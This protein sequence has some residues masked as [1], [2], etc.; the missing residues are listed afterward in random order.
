MV[1]NMSDTH[2]NGE[3]NQ[4][5]TPA[6]TANPLFEKSL[7]F[8]HFVKLMK[9]AGYLPF[10]LNSLFS[11]YVTILDMLEK[12]KGDP[13]ATLI[14]DGPPGVGK[15]FMAKAFAEVMKASY[16][17]YNC[18]PE[19]SAEELA[20]DINIIIP[21]LANSGMLT[22]EPT[23]EELILVG[24]LL[25]AI[26][27]S[28]TQRVVFL[29]DEQDKARSVVDALLLGVLQ[30]GYMFVNGIGENYRAKQVFSDPGNLIV[31]ITKNDERDLHPALLRRGRVIYMDYPPRSVE[32][33]LLDKRITQSAGKTVIPVYDN[34]E[35]ILAALTGI[36]EG[37][38]NGLITKARALRSASSITKPPSSPELERLANDFVRFIRANIRRVTRDQQ[39]WLVCDVPKPVLDKFM[40]DS[41]LAIKDEQS[42]GSK[43]MR[44]KSFGVN[45]MNAILRESGLVDNGARVYH[46]SEAALRQ[47]T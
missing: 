21:V 35:H 47:I 38:A 42:I 34:E 31:V 9:N 28:Q 37:P 13:L 10:D 23:P 2:S 39:S 20:V 17:Q 8:P 46:L 24:R 32:A 14:L 11:A 5:V 6:G 19:S 7:T 12:T 18:H 29:S 22:H 33:Q 27:A 16:L 3:G 41:L 40:L 43:V 36:G 4:L 26:Q 45:F 25:Q 1:N 15:S 44:D 30:D